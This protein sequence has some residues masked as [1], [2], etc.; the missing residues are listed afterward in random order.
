MARNWRRKSREFEMG[1]ADA[2]PDKTRACPDR[3]AC[4]GNEAGLSIGYN[5]HSCNNY[6]SLLHTHPSG[7]HRSICLD[8]DEVDARGG[9]AQVDFFKEVRAGMGKLPALDLPARDI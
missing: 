4:P 1:K 5:D 3:K 6:A 7:Y 8:A 2:M 9:T